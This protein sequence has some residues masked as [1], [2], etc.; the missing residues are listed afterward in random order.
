MGLEPTAG[1]ARMQLQR[2]E[3]L[4]DIASNLPQFGIALGLT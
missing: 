4:E 2:K 3:A 1:S